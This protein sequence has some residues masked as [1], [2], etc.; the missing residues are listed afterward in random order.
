MMQRKTFLLVLLLFSIP[1]LLCAASQWILV[2]STLTYHIS[3]PLHEAAGVSHAARGKGICQAGECNF[4]LAV[5]VKTF[6]SGNSNRDLHMI[7]AVHGAEFP[8]VIVRFRLPQSALSAATISANLQIQFAG[9][10]AQYKDVSFRRAAI[11]SDMKVTG[12]IPLK[13]T[14]FKIPLPELLF[15]P[16]KNLV[17]ITVDTTWRPQ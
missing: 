7:E 1:R 6:N 11:G 3:H 15:V 13:L 8:L 14:D 17:P 5:P 9:S 2:S 4:L 16:I 12:T 10:T